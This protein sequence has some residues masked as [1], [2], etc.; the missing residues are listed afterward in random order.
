MPYRDSHD[1]EKSCHLHQCEVVTTGSYISTSG[2]APAVS[3]EEAVLTGLTP[4]GGLYMPAQFRVLERDALHSI[5]GVPLLTVAATLAPIVFGERDVPAAVADALDFPIPLVRLSERLFVLELFHGPTLAFKDVGARVLA[6]LLAQYAA[7]EPV[8]VVTATSGDTGGAVA[9]AFEGVPNTR[10]FILYPHGQVTERQERQFATVGG[11]V[12][13][14]AIDG[15]FDDCQRLA[16]GVLA[17]SAFVRGTILT[18]AN[19]INVGRLLPQTIYYAHAWGQLPADVSEIVVSVPSGN[20]GNLTAGLIAKRVGVPIDHFVAATNAND[21]F[22]AFLSSGRYTPKPSVR[23][24]SSAMDVGDPSNFVRIQHLY[25]NDVDALRRDVSASSHTDDEV[26]SAIRDVF[27]RFGYVIDP[28]TA[29]G[30]LGLENAMASRPNSV[31]VVLATAHPA[32][33]SET[34]EPILGRTIDVPARLAALLD[35]EVNATSIDPTL[36]ALR[37][38]MQD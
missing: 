24:L 14:V 4:D 17:D 21:V 11:N 12:R 25:D 23:T 16:K 28:H 27:E 8:T 35:R 38:V 34:V 33:F 2:T 9:H 18:S 15:T 7:K 32:K 13:A 5:V 20:L 26:R 1:L 30:F 3:L 29:V 6:Q 10:V 37:Q 22:P 31:G 36:E 19:S